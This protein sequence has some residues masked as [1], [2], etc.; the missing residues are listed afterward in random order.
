MHHTQKETWM[1]FRQLNADWQSWKPS[2]HASYSWKCLTAIQQQG[3][4]H[5][6]SSFRLQY[7]KSQSSSAG[8]GKPM[9]SSLLSLR[10]F[11][12]AFSTSLGNPSKSRKDI[13]PSYIQPSLLS[14][15]SAQKR[16]KTED[17]TWIRDFLSASLRKQASRSLW[18]QFQ[19]P[20]SPALWTGSLQ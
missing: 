14:I 10:G 15:A 2:S 8:V 5:A 1:G 7:L 17:I 12:P 18:I 16:S 20:N 4:L 19:R 13:A 6:S 9:Y 3:S 11:K